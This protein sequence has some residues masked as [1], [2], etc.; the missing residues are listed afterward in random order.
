MGVA[1]ILV[2]D[3]DLANKLSF[4]ILLRLHMKFGFEKKIFEN[5][6]RQMDGRRRTIAIL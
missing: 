3:P 1:A 2:F 6:G 4:P 5:G